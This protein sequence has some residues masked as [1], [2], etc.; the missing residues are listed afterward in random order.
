MPIRPENRKRYP[1]EWPELSRFIRFKRAGG[2][3]ECHGECGADGCG[4]ERCS[5]VHGYPAPVSR[6]PVVLTTAHLNHQPEDCRPENLQAMCQRCHLAYDAEHHAE[7]RRLVKRAQE[8]VQYESDLF[9]DLF[10][11]DTVAP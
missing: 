8:I 9:G 2:R 10:G 6:K 1:T 11:G 5:A 7:T 4:P 3:C